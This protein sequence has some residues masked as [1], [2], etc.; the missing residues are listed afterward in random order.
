MFI[1][2]RFA[3][4]AALEHLLNGK[5]IRETFKLDY[6]I[7]FFLTYT[8]DEDNWSRRLHG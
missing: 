8:V 3:A 2:G 5:P 7:N 4:L 1:V 6:K